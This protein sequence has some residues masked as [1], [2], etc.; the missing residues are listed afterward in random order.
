MSAYFGPNEPVY[1]PYDTIDE[2][3]QD[4][5]RQVDDPCIDNDRFAWLGDFD[6]SE[7]N[8]K[9]ENGC[10]G[11]EDRLVLI[12]HPDWDHRQIAVIGCNYGH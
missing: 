7:Y 11:S 5:Y 3:F 9:S 12:T 2:A 6:F 1:G 8:E 10:C 4:M